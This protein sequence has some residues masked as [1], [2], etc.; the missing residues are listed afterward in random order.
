[1]GDTFEEKAKEGKYGGIPWNKL[2]KD[3]Y[4]G[5]NTPVKEGD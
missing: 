1:M 2:P 4:P 5:P 3:G